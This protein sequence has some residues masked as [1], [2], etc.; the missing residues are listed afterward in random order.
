MTILVLFEKSHNDINVSSSSLP[1]DI[2]RH[3]PIRIKKDI[4]NMSESFKEFTR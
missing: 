4:Y 1:N 3:E 2:K